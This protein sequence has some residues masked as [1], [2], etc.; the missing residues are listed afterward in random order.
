[1]DVRIGAD[2][3]P[4]PERHPCPDFFDTCCSLKSEEIVRE[5]VKPPIEKQDKCGIRNKKGSTFT[6]IER[7][8]EAQFGELIIF[9][10]TL[11]NVPI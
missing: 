7:E 5:V 11:K 10:K 2:D 8:H 9:N 4:Q 1:M 6:L 3:D